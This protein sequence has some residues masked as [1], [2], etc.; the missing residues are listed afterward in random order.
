LKKNYIFILFVIIVF[1]IIFIL[2]LKNH[3]SDSNIRVKQQNNIGNDTNNI[4][5]NIN[6]SIQDDFIYY[7]SLDGLFRMRIDSNKVTKLDD[8]DIKNINVVGEWIYYVKSTDDNTS[9]GIITHFD[10]YRMTINGNKKDII[11][12]NAHNVNI[13]DDR[14]FYISGYGLTG[15][16]EINNNKSLIVSDLSGNNKKVIIDNDVDSM[17]LYDNYIYYV[18]NNDMFIYD[19]KKD[20]NIPFIEN[21]GLPYIIN[22]NSII[23]YDKNVKQIKQINCETKNIKII[24][25]DVTNIVSL[26]SF[27]NILYYTDGNTHLYAY[28]LDEN[29]LHK[30]SKKAGIVLFYYD[31]IYMLTYDNKIIELNI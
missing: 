7:S 20:E 21:I 30:I 4:A 14:I 6:I 15:K 9:S 19:L 13:V 26:Y 29:Q 23:Y 5:Q 24:I 16:S 12:K 8:G 22:N 25:S 2:F 27:D 3:S 17:V 11:I 1:I 31:K 18:K 28:Y 10:L